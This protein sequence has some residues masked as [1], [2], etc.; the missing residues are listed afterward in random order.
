MYPEPGTLVDT[1]NVR[2]A[3]TSIHAN[4]LSKTACMSSHATL[5]MSNPGKSLK[6]KRNTAKKK[7]GDKNV[8][9]RNFSNWT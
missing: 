5:N 1:T 4:Q 9:F 3:A 2:E 6:D 8:R 7:V